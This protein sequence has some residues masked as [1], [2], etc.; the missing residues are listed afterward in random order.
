MEPAGDWFPDTSTYVDRARAN[1]GDLVSYVLTNRR[2]FLLG[3]VLL[4]AVCPGILR[5][6]ARG[7]LYSIVGLVDSL[8]FAPAGPGDPPPSFEMGLGGPSTFVA[9]FLAALGL[10][11]RPVAA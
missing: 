11:P 4:S 2:R 7:A 3:L 6:C 1:F 10:A 9:L 8:V 5:H